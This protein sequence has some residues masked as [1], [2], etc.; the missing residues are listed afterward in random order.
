M[1]HETLISCKEAARHL[2]DPG[3]VFVDCRFQMTDKDHGRREFLGSHIR[4]AVYASLDDDLSGTVVPGVTGRH[5]LPGREHLTAVISRFGIANGTQVVV[6]DEQAGQMA[7]ARLWW[8]L[9]WAGHTAAALLDGGFQRWQSLGLPTG[10][11]EHRNAPA[12]FQAVF[13]DDLLFEACDVEEVMAD[14]AWAL[15]DSRARDRYRGENETIDPVAG[16]IPGAVSAPFGDNIGA[17]GTMK[18]PGELR[19]RFEEEIGRVPGRQTVFYCGSGVTAA[20]NILSYVH[21]EGEMPRLYVG[22]WSDWITDRKRPVEIGDAGNPE[23]G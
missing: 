5:P 12:V 16:H 8:L 23:R 11:G 22:S 4:G 21:A 13:N 6:Y 17:D 7:A 1:P 9:R 2:E 18:T 15:V 3:W 19:K 14:T 20:Q 10:S